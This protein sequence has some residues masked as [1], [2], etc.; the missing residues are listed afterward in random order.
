MNGAQTLIAKSKGAMNGAQ[1]LVARNKGAINGEQSRGPSRLYDG[2][3]KLKYVLGIAAAAIVLAAVLLLHPWSRG[4]TQLAYSGTVETREIEVGSKLGGRVTTVA[5][6]EGQTVKAGALLV[7]F[8]ANEL[9]AERAQAA[10]QVEQAQADLERLERGYRPEEK[11][12]T[13]A[14]AAEQGAALEAAKNGP[15]AQ[16]L[17]QAR[18]DYES[19]K[20][21]ALDAATTFERMET[22]VRGD[23]I[24]RMQFDDA[25]AKRDSTAQRAES[26]R[27]RL[28]LLEAGTRPEDLRAAEQRF[29]QAQAAAE[30]MQRGYRREDLDAARGVLAAAIAHRKALDA[31]LSEAELTAAADGF[32]EVVSVRPGDLV[33][34]GKIVVTMLESS[35]LW[36][37]IYVPETELGGVKLGQAA[38]ISVDAYPGREFRGSVQEIGA[39]AE[40]LPRNVQTRDDR[41]HEVFGVK[42]HVDE[43]DG[44]LKSGMSATVHL[45]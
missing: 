14:A 41:E 15:R 9:T 7:R 5:V 8:E 21:D 23:T 2:C 42:V 3:M 39:Q 18:A 12:Q 26:L 4:K 44:V 33:P 35:Q 30:L 10:A 24:S 20:A 34:P 22:L 29:R 43:A 36:V 31:Q 13:Q 6:E 17:A 38:A 32:V 37:K 25:K 28:A 40:F 45:R 11:A 1:T 27:Q 19:A 16:E